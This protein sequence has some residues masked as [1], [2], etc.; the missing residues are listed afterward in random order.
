MMED[1]VI[2]TGFAPDEDL[3]VLLNG[4]LAYVQPSLYEGFGI[5]ALNALFCGVPVIVSKTASLPEVVGDAGVLFDPYSVEDIRNAIVRVINDKA[6]QKTMI[7]KGFKQAKKFSWE[8]MAK[9][10]IEVLEN[11]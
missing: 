11:V 10:V 1:R 9:E 8:K 3:P 4:A 6:L 2:F 7:Q 5:P